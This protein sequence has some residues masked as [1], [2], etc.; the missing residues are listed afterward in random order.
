M[1]NLKDDSITFISSK[2]RLILYCC[3]IVVFIGG[4]ILGFILLFKQFNWLMIGYLCFWVICV[5]LV[6]RVMLKTIYIV[7]VYDDKLVFQSLLCKKKIVPFS[8][9]KN[10]YNV[11]MGREGVVYCIETENSGNIMEWGYPFRFDCTK[12]TENIIQKI[13]GKEVEKLNYD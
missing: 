7:K 3:A 13:W 8:V 1:N 2:P 4:F 12:K 9:I 5:G 10:I 6:L 11:N